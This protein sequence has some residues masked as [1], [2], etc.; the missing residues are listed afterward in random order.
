MKRLILSACL[1]SLFI[2]AFAE[3][4][5]DGGKI[6]VDGKPFFIRGGE[7]GNSGA[8]CAEDID[9]AFR[10]LKQMHLNTL[11][12]P[13]YWDMLE[14]EEG[15]YDFSQVD[16]IISA[17]E[18][19]D[20]RVVPL[21]FGAWKNS[22]SCYAPAYVKTD[23]KRYPRARTSAGKA[24]EIASPF[25]PAILEADKRAF[26]ELCRHIESRDTSERVIMV[27]I[28]NEIGMLEDA[29]DH[30]KGADAEY[31]RGVPEKLTSWL[32]AH[33]RDMHPWLL[34]RWQA[35]GCKSGG[36]WEEVFGEG[37]ETDEIFQAW[38][39]AGYVQ[40]L[41]RLAKSINGR[42]V[43]VNAALNSRGRKPGQY[44]SAGPLAH[45][46]DVWQAAAPDI[47]MISP[48]I[49]DTGFESWTAQYAMPDNA[50]FVPEARRC[51]ANGAQALYIL[52][53]HKALGFSPFSIEN[54]NVSAD[55][56][57][58]HAY[59]II[60][61]IYGTAV[62]NQTDGA[63][64]DFANPEITRTDGDLRM[65]LSHFYTLPWDPAA[66]DTA[67]WP[68][69]GC[70]IVKLAP[71]DYIIAG[72]GVVAKFEDASGRSDNARLGEDGFA[73]N[74]DAGS[75][76]PASEAG[77]RIGILD[78]SQI[79]IDDRGEMHVKRRYNGDETHQGRH[80]RIPVGRWEILRVRLYEY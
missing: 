49:Y 54:G 6:I 20:M 16:M 44:P 17:A 72:T 25:Y 50:L 60:D 34:S 2:A 75:E 55:D 52:G 5:F 77:R 29:R 30:S 59:R 24:L 32:K 7:L 15:K 70:V 78:V 45:L 47:D 21:W 67:N 11:L 23:T 76:I 80:A 39:Y 14:P 43:Y 8:S 41:A 74:G 58:A 56:N 10:R 33:K 48:D 13:V 3:S 46:K 28:E 53:K 19:E 36:T 68:T 42:P 57:L 35:N 27:Q 4:R 73:L 79:E 69:T 51:D 63:L 40:H 61:Q 12:V 22:M 37:I 66:A 31:R 1:L 71:M 38:A 18:R 64:F 9:D 62:A 65:T 26:G